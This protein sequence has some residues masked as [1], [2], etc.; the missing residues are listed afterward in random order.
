MSNP[1][2]AA[3]LV[4]GPGV[5][6][7]SLRIAALRNE[8]QILHDLRSIHFFGN[9]RPILPPEIFEHHTRT[10]VF[11]F[12]Y[13]AQDRIPYLGQERRNEGFSSD[14]IL[15]FF[16]NQGGAYDERPYRKCHWTKGA[17]GELGRTGRIGWINAM[18]TGFGSRES[19]DR[20]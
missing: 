18:G 14:E 20:T 3:T 11:L 17:H 8:D 1:I 2:G 4:E 10:G 6:E 16:S 5:E 19:Q 15:G 7:T 9:A 13:G 12:P